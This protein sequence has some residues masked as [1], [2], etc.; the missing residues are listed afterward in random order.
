MS[1]PQGATK[2]Y[3]YSPNRRA[4]N[5]SPIGSL[6]LP[7]CL[8]DAYFKDKGDNKRPLIPVSVLNVKNW[9]SSGELNWTL[10]F[11]LWITQSGTH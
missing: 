10:D 1:P 7:L 11:H 2:W 4:G 8:F 3:P 9:L 6:T 5:E